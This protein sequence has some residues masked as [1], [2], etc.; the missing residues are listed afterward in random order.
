[1]GKEWQTG[2][3]REG[4]KERIQTQNYQR[5]DPG[6]CHQDKNSVDLGQET[7]H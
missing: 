4:G 3:Q 6:I 7:Q 1:M 5:S 2:E